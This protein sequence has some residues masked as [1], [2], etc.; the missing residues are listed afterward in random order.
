MQLQLSSRAVATLVHRLCAPKLTP[1][2]KAAFKHERAL[3][4]VFLNA[5]KQAQDAVPMSELEQALNVPGT[6]AP[7]YV[8]QP[9]FDMLLEQ[10]EH[11]EYAPY[12]RVAAASDSVANVLGQT[13][14]DGAASNELCV[15]SN[16]KFFHTTSPKK[17]DSILKKGLKADNSGQNFSTLAGGSKEG[18]VY[19]TSTVK[20]ARFWGHQIPNLSREN[21][22]VIFEI[23]IPKKYRGRL[24]ADEHFPGDSPVNFQ[25]KGNIKPEWI[26]SWTKMDLLDTNTPM[27]WR[28]LAANGR[29]FAPVILDWISDE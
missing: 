19:V 22:A 21:D 17:L 25:F 12:M 23:E 28:K 5:I 6:G 2:A 8:L 10:T 15:V 20:E 13:M 16:D 24:K 4:R 7:L 1:V 26:R 11:R 14:A 18:H 27:K 29:V 9:V 3:A